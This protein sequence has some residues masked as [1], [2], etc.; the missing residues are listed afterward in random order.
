M[1]PAIN[2]LK[3]AKIFYQ[4]HEYNHDPDSRAYGKE[5]AEKLNLS[6]DQI[7]KTLVVSDGNNGLSVAVVPVSKQLDLKLFAKKLKIKKTVMAAKNDVQRST[8][9][10]LGGVSPIGQKK[11][12]KT[13]IDSSALK[14]DTIFVSAGRRGLQIEL[15]PN[16]LGLQTNGYFHNISN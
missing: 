3:K 6:F 1:T 13:V 15:S 16:D 8:G 12:L 5:A 7:F 4:I 9:Y 10:I 2:C 11:R 14:F